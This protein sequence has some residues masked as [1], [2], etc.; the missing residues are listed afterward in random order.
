[1][2]LEPLPTYKLIQ[3]RTWPIPAISDAEIYTYR[4]AALWAEPE[5]Y[6]LQ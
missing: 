6:P 4:M 5:R 2:A 1:M 3:F